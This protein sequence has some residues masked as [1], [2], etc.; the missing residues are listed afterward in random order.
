MLRSLALVALVAVALPASSQVTADGVWRSALHDYRVAT[1]VE[2]LEQP[3]SI[4]FLPGGD[5]L[6]TERPGRLR[7]VRNGKLV[8]EPVAGVPRVFLS[9]QGGLLEVMPHPS[10]ASDR[11]LY[12]SYSKAGA[13]DSEAT[14]VLARGRFVSDR[15]TDVQ[16][17]FTAV[18]QGRNHF[19]GKIAFDKQGYLYLSAGDRQVPPA[20]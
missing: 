3:W 16:E 13:T 5:L 17:I 11:L 2:A 14:T 12:L 1:V 18:A 20:G 10:F 9:S 4:A 6:I 8:A 7:I 15:L 19:S